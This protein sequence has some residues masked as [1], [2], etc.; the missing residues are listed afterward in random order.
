[1]AY[2]W[3]E[4]IS[5]IKLSYRS[6]IVLKRHK[7][8]SNCDEFWLLHMNCVSWLATKYKPTFMCLSVRQYQIIYFVIVRLDDI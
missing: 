6:L 7:Q 1:M 4:G 8:L 5:R 2:Q 3:P